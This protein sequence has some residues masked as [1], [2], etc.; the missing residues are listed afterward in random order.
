M[1]SVG[2][3]L[4]GVLL[5]A[6]PAMAQPRD[7]NCVGAEGLEADVISL[8]FARNT[9]ALPDGARDVLAPLAE[10][11]RT[12]H[13]RNICVLGFAAADEGGA[14]TAARLA[15]RRARAVALELSQLGVERDRIRAETRTRGFTPGQ[16]DRRAGVR[17]I[18]MPS[19]VQPEPVFP[20]PGLLIEF[21]PG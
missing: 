19:I 20:A 17:V 5:G 21:S 14:Q 16:T 2:L 12:E 1:R 13:H 6:T 3:I 11:A 7:F 18:L 4:A 9:A 10:T 15:A 8:G